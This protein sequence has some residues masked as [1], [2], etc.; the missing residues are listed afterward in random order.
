LATQLFAA[1]MNPKAALT[2]FL[3][4]QADGSRSIQTEN[5]FSTEFQFHTP[6]RH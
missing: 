6:Q 1:G 3:K 4:R 5:S 2:R